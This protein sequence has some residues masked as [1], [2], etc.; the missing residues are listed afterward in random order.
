MGRMKPVLIGLSIGMLMVGL[1]TSISFYYLSSEHFAH[2]MSERISDREDMDIELSEPLEW[3][4][5]FPGIRAHVPKVFV[6]LS[7]PSYLTKGRLSDVD[8]SVSIWALLGNQDKPRVTLKASKFTAIHTELETGKTDDES[9]AES[10]SSVGDVLVGIET[11]L[12]YQ[13][14][15]SIAHL[16]LFLRSTESSTHYE[17]KDTVFKVRSPEITMDT[18][19]AVDGAVFRAYSLKV[20]TTPST[21][22][23]LSGT[24]ELATTQGLD[25]AQR[26]LKVTSDFSASKSQLSFSSLKLVSG[27]NLL[28]GELELRFVKQLKPSVRGELKLRRFEL[29]DFIRDDIEMEAVG[30][31]RFFT[32]AY[33]PYE[34]FSEIEIDF[35]IKA[36]A[37]RYQGQPL[38]NGEIM[39]SNHE[40]TL[41]IDAPT[42]QL[43]GAP[44]NLSIQA[45]DMHLKPVIK[46]NAALTDVHLKRFNFVSAEQSLFDRGT[47][48][49]RI[50]LAMLGN[51]T[52][53]HTST[54]KGE[55][56]IATRETHLSPSFVEWIDKGVISHIKA[57]TNK[58]PSKQHGQ[59]QSIPCASMS[60][61]IDN[62]YAIAYQSIL[63]ETPENLLIS[64]GYVDFHT[65]NIGFT[66]RTDSKHLV[67]WS[68]LS[69]IKY[70]RISGKLTEPKITINQQE[71][72]KQ[73]ALTAASLFAG[74][75]P[76]LAYAAIEASKKQKQQ[77]PVCYPNLLSSR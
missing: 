22:N 27:K 20:K 48:D 67:D 64:N 54:L 41:N 35:L 8:I 55:F 13:I 57:L 61:V 38:I 66:F 6:N 50:S 2:S 65:E 53:E 16:S 76:G 19:Y 56:I 71:S 28:N 14:N 73:G 34:L 45:E 33:I 49:V 74:P 7:G 43:F 17:L 63:L 58:N 29:L 46:I 51:S 1:A 70:M 11:V 44:A 31:S 40:N 47:G 37:V 69:A 77:K 52:Y 72:L 3:Q 75:I 42:L 39:L 5:F 15:A 60:F 23:G 4:L 26:K 10:L 18:E 59:G 12:D 21:L 24:I 25:E 68:P 62:G 36:G 32:K 30:E 9:L